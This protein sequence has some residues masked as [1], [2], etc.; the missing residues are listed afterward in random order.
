[1]GL[2]S[3]LEPLFSWLWYV[4]F[5]AS[6]ALFVYF[7][8]IGME[9]LFDGM[10]KHKNNKIFSSNNNSLNKSFRQFQCNQIHQLDIHHNRPIQIKPA[11]LRL[12]SLVMVTL[13]NQELIYLLTL[14][15]PRPTLDHL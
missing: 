2:D 5:A 13:L 7:Q 6:V 1:M 10:I 3:L 15:I 8:N 14:I 4:A 11:I 9:E 12:H